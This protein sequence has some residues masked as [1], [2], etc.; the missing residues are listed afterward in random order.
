VPAANDASGNPIP[1]SLTVYVYQ[2]ARGLPNF[3]AMGM[4]ACTVNPTVVQEMQDICENY[5]SE[6]HEG[7]DECTQ[8]KTCQYSSRFDIVVDDEPLCNNAGYIPGRPELGQRP[9]CQCGF[10]PICHCECGWEVTGSSERQ[11]S[12]NSESS[13]YV[14][15]EFVG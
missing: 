13:S 4:Q 2:G 7:D 11:Y 5:Q 1:Q 14:V 9:N 12:G 8:F 3:D 15:R 6:C 10:H